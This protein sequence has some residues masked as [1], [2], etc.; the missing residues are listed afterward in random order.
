VADI[1]EIDAYTSAL[2]GAQT[3]EEACDR[4]GAAGCAAAVQDESVVIGDGEATATP[5]EGVNQIGDAFY[6]WRL[7]D[8]DGELVRCVP[9]GPNGSCPPRH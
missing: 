2:A 5:F 6:L 3:T 7:L 4:L 1:A 9:R 8:R